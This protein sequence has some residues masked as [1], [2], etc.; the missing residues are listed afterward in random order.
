MTDERF[1]IH[2]SDAD[3]LMWNIEK[4]PLLRSTIVTVLLLDRAPEWSALVQRVEAGTRVIP[5][6][7]Q[8]VASPM[9]R[10][11]PPIWSADPHFDIGFHMHRVASCDGTIDGSPLAGNSTLFDASISVRA[12]ICASSDS[13]T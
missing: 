5:R 11:G 4:D 2:M 12:S 7:R 1:E 9:L 6:L 10:V 13:G 8:R 3:A